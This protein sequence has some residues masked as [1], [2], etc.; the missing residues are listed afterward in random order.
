[1][2]E[3]RDDQAGN[4]GKTKQEPKSAPVSVR[5]VTD[6]TGLSQIKPVQVPYG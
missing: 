6:K 1:M 2:M 3:W 5:Y 4:G